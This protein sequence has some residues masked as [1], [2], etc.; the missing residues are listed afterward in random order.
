ADP[1]LEAHERR[2]VIA[3]TLAR[4]NIW[5]DHQADRYKGLIA[6]ALDHRWIMVGLAALSFFLAIALQIV[7]GGFGFVPVSDQSEL[8]IAVQT[9]PGSSLDYTTL[10]AEEVARMVRARPEVL[11]T[12]TTVGS[13]TGSRE[14][15]NGSIYVRLKPKN[16][17][18]IRQEALGGVLRRRM[19][20]LGGATAFTYAS[21][22]GG[23]Q[24]QL[25]LQLQGPDPTIL[26][27]LAEK[28][29]AIVR[30]VP[31]AVD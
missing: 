2:N 15:D 1:Q 24:K 31:G 20:L 26:A 30:S 19:R 28:I 12:Y 4:F 17:R 16:Q 21:G 27:Q 5:F 9:P 8:N 23:A 10:K 7:I 3:R 25:Q 11:Y 29:E 14:V 22:F 18:S 6:W 13:S